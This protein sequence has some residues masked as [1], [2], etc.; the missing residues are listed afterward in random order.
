MVVRLALGLPKLRAAVRID[1][2]LGGEVWVGANRCWSWYPGFAVGLKGHSKGTFDLF[3]LFSLLLRTPVCHH[4]PFHF[5]QTSSG[6]QILVSTFL[7]VGE[8]FRTD[9]QKRVPFFVMATGRGGGVWTTPRSTKITRARA[10]HD[11]GQ[12]N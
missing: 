6:V 5:S 1:P 10:R 3:D 2:D 11:W 8:P 12:V 4:T 9:D 7:G